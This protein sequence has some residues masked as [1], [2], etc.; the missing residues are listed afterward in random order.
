MSRP[1]IPA[2]YRGMG[3]AIDRWPEETWGWRGSREGDHVRPGR[4]VALAGD[5]PTA[6]G[7]PLD[8]RRA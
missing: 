2:R 6:M 5:K 3:H 7:F 8:S 1:R 4:R